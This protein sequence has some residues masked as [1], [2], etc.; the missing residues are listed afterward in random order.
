[1]PYPKLFFIKYT[2]YLI[3]FLPFPFLLPPPLQFRAFSSSGQGGGD[4][5][6]LRSSGDRLHALGPLS[7]VLHWELSM[8]GGLPSYLT[9]QKPCHGHHRN[10]LDES[11]PFSMQSGWP[12]RFATV[13]EL[14]TGQSFSAHALR[15]S[16]DPKPSFYSLLSKNS[17]YLSREEQSS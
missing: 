8:C 14:V 6:Q 15:M 2:E 1:M 3:Y 12:T 11:R 13:A 16:C 17:I 4:T 7:Y 5:G 10:V 9:F